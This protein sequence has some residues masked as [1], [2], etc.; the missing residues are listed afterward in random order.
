MTGDEAVHH[1]G[2]KAQRKT[3]RGSKAKKN[4]ERKT[5]ER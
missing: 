3:K 5:E 2:H 4:T 1:R